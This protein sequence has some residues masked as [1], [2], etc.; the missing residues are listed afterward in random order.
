MDNFSNLD[1][2]L[3]DKSDPLEVDKFIHENYEKFLANHASRIYS[4]RYDGKLVGFFTLSMF[5]VESKSLN[6]DDDLSQISIN[7]YPSLLLGQMGVEK[8]SRGL[9]IGVHIV[10]FCSGLGQLLN[11]KGGLCLFG[12]WT[13]RELAETY[14]EPNCKLKWKKSNK[15]KVWMYKKLF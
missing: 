6:D 8:E 9:D 7:N 15:Q 14:Y 2:T 10:R 1:F 13:T 4:V 11:D 5:H 12:I 3:K